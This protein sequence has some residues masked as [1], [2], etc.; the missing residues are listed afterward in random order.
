MTVPFTSPLTTKRNLMPAVQTAAFVLV[1]LAFA[2][3]GD[4]ASGSPLKDAKQVLDQQKSDI[5]AILEWVCY[6]AMAIGVV[7]GVVA[8]TV[9][10]DK[11]WAIGGG[12][13]LLAG[14][15]GLALVS[16]LMS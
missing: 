16:T 4:A 11:N 15:L 5:K 1:L 9:M 12:I 7:I 2:S 10:K 8:A 14:A 6:I 13:G 3:I